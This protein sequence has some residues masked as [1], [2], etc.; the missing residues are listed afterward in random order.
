MKPQMALFVMPLFVGEN[1]IADRRGVWQRPVMPVAS[2]W[3]RLWRGDARRVQLR[4]Y[5][6]VVDGAP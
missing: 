3:R 4:Y 6:V 2:S 1:N 5:G